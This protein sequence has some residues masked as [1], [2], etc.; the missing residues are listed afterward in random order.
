MTSNSHYSKTSEL[1]PLYNER[2]H[3]TL[4]SATSHH[5]MTSE[6]TPLNSAVHPQVHT[7]TRFAHE[8]CSSALCTRECAYSKC[9]SFTRQNDLLYCESLACECE[10]V[11]VRPLSSHH[12]TTSELTPLYNQRAHTTLRLASSHHSTTCELTPLYDQ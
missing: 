12:S 10:I 11:G 9:Y 5:S 8:S 4:R 6:L 1:T 2:A 7:R 3:T